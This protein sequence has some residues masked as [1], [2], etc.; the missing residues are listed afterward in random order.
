MTKISLDMVA[1]ISPQRRAETN[2]VF[3][4]RISHRSRLF[5]LIFSRKG[6]G[7]KNKHRTFD[8]LAQCA[9]APLQY[10]SVIVTRLAVQ[11]C[12]IKRIKCQLFNVANLLRST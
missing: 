10:R 8:S 11:F 6:T 1:A 7:R 12:E 9:H 5:L 3:M 2:F 4:M